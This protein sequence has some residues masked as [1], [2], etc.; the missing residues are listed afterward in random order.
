MLL[1]QAT[2]APKSSATARIA[3]SADQTKNKVKSKAELTETGLSGRVCAM[4][5]G[6]GYKG[7]RG[8]LCS[9]GVIAELGD[10]EIEE[11][12]LLFHALSWHA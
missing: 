2:L 5:I 12:T 3:P 9:S 10:L 8:G 6:L 1:P 11:K 4:E 7:G